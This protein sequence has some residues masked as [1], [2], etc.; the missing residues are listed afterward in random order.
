MV[1]LA[2]RADGQFSKRVAIKVIKRGMDTNAVIDR[3]HRERRILAALD[4]P[5][6]CRLLDGGTTRDGLPYI[7][8]DYV[9]GLPIDRW[10]DER[11]LS[12]DQ[13]CELTC[14]VCEAVAYAHRS[15]VIHRDL[16]PGNILVATDGNPK[17]LDFGIAKILGDG[18]EPGGEAETRFALRP[19]TPEYAS[20][21]QIAGGAVGTATDAYSLGVVLFELLAGTRPQ[22]EAEKAS[23]AALRNGK[24][25]RWAR[26]VAGVAGDLD[27][28]I[29]MALRTEIERRY[30]G[31]DQLLTDLRLHLNGMPVSAQPETRLYRWGKFVRRHRAGVVAAALIMLSLAGGLATTLWQARRAEAERQ[32]ADRR[33]SQVR[34]LAG[35][36]MFDLHDAIAAV[37]GSTPVRKMVVETGIR[38]NDSL[39]R[40]AGGNRD[41]LEEIARGYDR[42][43]DVQGNTYYAN[44]GDLAGA[45]A[46]YK[47]AGAIRDHISDSSPGFLRDRAQGY[48]RLGEILLSKGD[49]PGSLKNFKLAAALGGDVRAPHTR[50]MRETVARVWSRLGDGYMNAKETGKAA[51]AYSKALSVRTEL[52]ADAG[53]NAAQ[54]DVGLAHDKLADLFLTAGRIA[55][56]F[57]H[58]SAA[59]GIFRNLTSAE[60]ANLTLS[61]YI[62]LAAQLA[63]GAVE[64]GEI[65]PFDG[66]SS[67]LRG[68][69]DLYS[70]LLVVDPGDRRAQ[71]DLAYL[72]GDLGDWL[73]GEKNGSAAAGVWQHAIATAKKLDAPGL[74]GDDARA[75]I[76]EMYRR[77]ATSA[78]D[79]GRYGEALGN[80]AEAEEYAKR[81]EA[82]DPES[83][84]RPLLLNEIAGVRADIF[85]VRRSWRDAIRELTAIIASDQR[86]FGLKPWNLT[87]LNDEAEKYAVLAR[88]YVENRQQSAGLDAMQLAIGRYNAIAERRAMTPADK[89]KR[90]EA[91]AWLA[92][93][94][95]R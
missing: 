62:C 73:F 82:T 52:A 95:T 12:V 86:A 20:P 7:V 71:N 25:A 59:F 26:N 32:L 61:R 38:Y 76:A 56:S 89:R 36:L 4:H 10:C 30:L 50:E 64:R 24:G 70:K 77:L 78:M 15:L 28:I 90:G 55:E 74:A 84:W 94:R 88:C 63:A 67:Q 47:K 91:S 29:Q 13:R 18:A 43:G 68:C 6:I 8:M 57:E 45:E 92:A 42:L 3:F 72:E 35:K 9:E 81:V 17:L 31:V 27:A 69:R 58:S 1:Y 44:L 34:E 48:L 79:G 83:V 40:E 66:I 22:N 85:M 87:P 51:E 39:L 54:R 19:F 49:Y 5:Y 53:D 16:K 2:T 46:S 41:L 11:G 21:E 23:A 60:P 75:L 93:R 37:P 80:L 33:F 65:I 14:K